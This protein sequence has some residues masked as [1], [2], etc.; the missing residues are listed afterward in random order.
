ME[1]LNRFFIDKEIN[2]VLDVGTGTGNFIAVL[3][4]T[5]VEATIVGV[6][7]NVESLAEAV[8]VYPDVSFKEMV[9]E[10]LDFADQTFDVASISMALHHV[11][12]VALT[13]SE[14]QRV[15]KPGGW[16]IINE[17]FSD[18]LNPAQEVHKAMHHFRSKI[19][20]LNGV[21][22]NETFTK[23]QILELTETAGLNIRLHF[24]NRKPAKNPTPEEID[25]R[26]AKL[27]EMLDQV[28][29]KPEFPELEIESVRIEAALKQH[30]FEMATCVVVVAEVK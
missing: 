7:P 26:L 9:G 1:K 18:N 11:P 6:D 13:L 12:D 27:N 17:L 24:E 10:K 25:E 28:K 5:F 3:K 23:Q 21:S 15:V 22:H 20:R 14:M 4:E 16:V 2:S 8:K 30:G 29:N 19:D